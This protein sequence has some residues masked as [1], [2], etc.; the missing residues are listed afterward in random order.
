M[1]ATAFPVGPVRHRGAGGP[2]LIGVLLAG[3]PFVA[4]R[5]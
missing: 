2:I 1:V 3:M 5:S 4:V